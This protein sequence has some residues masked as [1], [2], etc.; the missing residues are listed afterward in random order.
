MTKNK[1]LNKLSNIQQILQYKN[2]YCDFETVIYKNQHYVV[3]YSIV[4]ENLKLF[5]TITLTNQ[6]DI[7]SQPDLLIWEF[8]LECVKIV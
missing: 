4:G 7:P 2:F 8:I 6:D 1:Y 5:N 3:C